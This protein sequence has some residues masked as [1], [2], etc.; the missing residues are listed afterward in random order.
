M[1][2]CTGSDEA[3]RR[4]RARDGRRWLVTLLNALTALLALLLP[5][6]PAF[7][8]AAPAA[9]TRIRFID[10]LMRVG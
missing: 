9:G 2:V 7:A 3:S 6:T 4:G 1:R 8:V 10:R 5:A